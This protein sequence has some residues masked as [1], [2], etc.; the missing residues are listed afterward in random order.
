MGEEDWDGLARAD[1]AP[2]RRAC[3]SSATTCSSPT[4]SACA[5]ASSAGVANAILVKVNQIGTLTETLDA[6]RIAREA[7]LRAR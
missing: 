7:G 3:S 1:R 6:M 4:P 2:R 5:G